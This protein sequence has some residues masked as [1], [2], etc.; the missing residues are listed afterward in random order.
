MTFKMTNLEPLTVNSLESVNRARRPNP[1]PDSI[2]HNAS[3]I[4]SCIFE[5]LSIG[6][7]RSDEQVF[8]R[9]W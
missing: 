1:A 3:L 7:A 4:G 6:V 9:F 2:M 5:T 8:D